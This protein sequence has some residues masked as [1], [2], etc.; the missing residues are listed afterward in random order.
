MNGA[1]ALT[2][3]S[4]DR[5]VRFDDFARQWRSEMGGEPQLPAFTAATIAD[6]RVRTR[7][8]RVHDVTFLDLDGTSALQTAGH[9]T[10]DDDC[11]RLW[12]VHR[13]AL[14]LSKARHNPE[15]TVAPERFL[16][17]HVGHLTQ[18]ATEPDTHA[19]LLVVPSAELVP[20]LGRRVIAGD[21]G[22]A[23]VRLLVAHATMTQRLL[24]EL[25]APGVHAA[26]DALVELTKAVAHG[27]VDGA[28][29]RLAP[30]LAQAAKDLADQRL[31]D[32]DLNPGMLAGMLNVSVRTLQRAFANDGTSVTAYI[33]D[34]RLEMVRLA[35]AAPVR[36][37]SIGEIAARWQF[38]DRSHLTRTFQRR[39]G[40]SPAAYAREIQDRL[41]SG[42]RPPP[43]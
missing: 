15:Y 4:R 3:D 5:T 26:R 39:Y 30:A 29:P 37:L 40:S 20:L 35:L 2:L 36:Q 33:R 28:E 7:I 13:G 43:P 21:A 25:G 19:Q 10:P 42:R 27:D 11:V 38:A 22:A 6:Y 32:P 31:T 8:A 14:T 41:R 23:E 12:I 17:R 9:P 1:G 18:F 24:P 34:R 16:L